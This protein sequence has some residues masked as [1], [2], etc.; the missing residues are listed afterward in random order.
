MNLFVDPTGT[1][2]DDYDTVT[3]LTE[4]PTTLFYR[5]TYIIVWYIN[6]TTRI[7]VFQY[8][9]NNDFSVSQQI[10]NVYNIELDNNNYLTLKYQV[11]TD[12]KLNF[13][14]NVQCEVL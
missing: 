6:Q 9:D 7:G 2:D 3:F 5:V 1:A 14:K 10:E 4:I 13:Y 12:Q 8:R 11:P